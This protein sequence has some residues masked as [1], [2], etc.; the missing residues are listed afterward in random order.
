MDLINKEVLSKYIIDVDK[1]SIESLDITD[2]VYFSPYY[3]NYISNSKLK[4]INPDEDGSFIKY[5]NGLKTSYTNSLELGDAIHKLILQSESFELNDHI[6]PSGKLGKIIEYIFKYRNK[7]FKIYD[8]IL[9]SIKEIN[10]YNNRNK[11][12]VIKSILS[13]GIKYYLFLLKNKNIKFD[14][15]Q[16]ILDKNNYL[17]TEKCLE[18]LRKNSDAMN[19]L[20]PDD[21]SL[22]QYINK[23]EDTIILKINVT[24]PNSTI[25]PNAEMVN[26]KLK[27]KIKIDN[28]NFNINEGILQLNDLKTTGKPWYIFPGSTV[29]ETNEFIEGSFQHYHYYR[30][31]AFYNWVITQYLNNLGYNIKHNYL[32]IISVQTIPNF[33]CKVFN[34]PQ[35]WY[36]KGLFEFKKLICYAAYAEYNRDKILNI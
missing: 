10:Y 33:I 20:K 25:D 29:K 11:D 28:W 9:Y 35:K 1:S 30:Q 5:L 23:N 12:R 26:I 22:D 21:F 17:I 14:K 32:N 4:L 27:L 36:Y 24:F 7:G 18:S 16:I 3:S 8:S 6:K 2:E 31:L 15:E 19:I 34:I 13:S